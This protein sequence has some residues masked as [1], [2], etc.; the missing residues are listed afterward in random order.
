MDISQL[1]K[2]AG[3]KA[4][5]MVENGMTLGVGTGST[6]AYFI[7]E[8]G[9]RHREE[10]LEAHCVPTSIRSAQALKKCGYDG[11]MSLESAHIPDFNTA[12]KDAIKAFEWF[13]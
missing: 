4:C 7:E 1:K 6:V 5:Q 3:V 10:G 11:R 9:R 13:K 8:L 2:E 12:A